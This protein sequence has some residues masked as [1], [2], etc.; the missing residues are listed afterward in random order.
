M[1]IKFLML[2][3]L[4]WRSVA[5]QKHDIA[6]FTYNGFQGVSMILDGLAQI[7]DNGL[8]MLVNSTIQQVLLQAIILGLINMTNIG[9]SSNHVFAIELDC[10]QKQEFNDIDGNHV[11]I[12]INDLISI[13]SAPASYFNREENKYVNLS[14]NNEQPMQLWVEYNGAEKQLN[15]TLAP[16]NVPKPKIPL[17]SS[18]IDLSKI[19]LEPMFVGFSSATKLLPSSYYVLGWSFKMNGEARE[20]TISQ[21]P[22]L[23]HQKRHRRK[24]RRLFL[25][26]FSVITATLVVLI[27]IFCIIQFI[28]KTKKKFTEL[29]E[30]WELDYGPHIFKYKDLYIAT[31]GFK[32]KELLGSGGFG[33]VY[34]GVLPTSKTSCSEAS[35]SQF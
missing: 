1:V 2:F 29:L 9:K 4:L 27:L 15:V 14:L 3:L 30:D 6:G 23:P 13:E 12:D 28:V 17:L 10:I 31:K 19:I 33:S 26:S 24:P 25:V 34:R 21:L 35:L 7:T 20:L 5:S 32:D 8:L 22:K 11:G 18:K 16:I